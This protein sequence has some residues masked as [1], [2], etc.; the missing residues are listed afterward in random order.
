MY[1]GGAILNF[2]IKKAVFNRQLVLLIQ[3]TNATMLLYLKTAKAQFKLLHSTY[4]TKLHLKLFMLII[5]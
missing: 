2:S 5:Y 1:T 4:P 3:S